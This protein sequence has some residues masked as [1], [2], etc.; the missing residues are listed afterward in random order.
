MIHRRS[1]TPDPA[2]YRQYDQA[3]Q[4][5]SQIEASYSRVAQA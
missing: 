1:R 2:A 4:T 3:W 5:V